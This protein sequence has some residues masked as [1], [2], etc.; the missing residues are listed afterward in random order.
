MRLTVSYD[1]RYQPPAPAPGEQLLLGHSRGLL[2]P[3]R[4]ADGAP[5]CWWCGEGRLVGDLVAERGWA[6]A[7]NPQERLVATLAEA[8]LAREAGLIQGRVGDVL[9]CVVDE[10]STL[11]STPRGST[12]QRAMPSPSRS[13]AGEPPRPSVS[14]A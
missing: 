7:V 4:E 3:R 13:S 5:G 6:L 2:L 9:L 11:A 12:P 10:L 8:Y 14:D 1:R